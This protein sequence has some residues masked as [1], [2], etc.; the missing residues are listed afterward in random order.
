MGHSE[1][2]L[3]EDL[4]KH[5]RSKSSMHFL[6]DPD[7]VGAT[8]SRPFIHQFMAKKWCTFCS[9]GRGLCLGSACMGVKEVSFEWTV[10]RDTIV[11]NT[12]MTKIPGLVE[13]KRGISSKINT[14]VGSTTIKI[15][16]Q[17]FPCNLPSVKAKSQKKESSKSRTPALDHSIKVR[18]KSFQY[19]FYLITHFH[20]RVRKLKTRR[21]KKCSG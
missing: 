8:S 20:R 3:L 4:T 11:T 15:A 7:G 19:L 9:Y 6:E 13:V 18:N 17:K 1:M 21:Q 12:M 10:K 16:A 2:S 14:S 5:A